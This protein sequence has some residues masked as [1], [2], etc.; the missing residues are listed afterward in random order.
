[1]INYASDL[2]LFLHHRHMFHAMNVLL[3]YIDVYW[4]NVRKSVKKNICVKFKH[5]IFFNCVSIFV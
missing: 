3:K 5:Q 1:M 2:N 4:C